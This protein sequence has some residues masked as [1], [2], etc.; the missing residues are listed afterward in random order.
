MCHVIVPT[1]NTPS[2]LVAYWRALEVSMDY[3]PGEWGF[4]FTDSG[5]VIYVPNQDTPVTGKVQ[6]YQ[7]EVWITFTS[8]SSS[9]DTIKCLYSIGPDMAETESGTL[10]CG[11]PGG[12]APS[13]IDYAEATEGY[14]VHQLQKCL[15]A[16]GTCVFHAPIDTLFNFLKGEGATQDPCNQF[17]TC[18]TCI[19]AATGL[20]GWCSEVHHCARV[21]VRY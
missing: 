16:D 6:S 14:T 13:S 11:S 7:D 20:C 1:N 12:D 4:N 2:A 21:R 5:V 18:A 9:G 3:T 8:G 17:S 10:A 19:G 15:A